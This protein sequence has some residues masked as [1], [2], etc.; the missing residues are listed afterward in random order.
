MGFRKQVE[1]L[2]FARGRDTFSGERGKKKEMDLGIS[3]HH[4][5]HRQYLLRAYY[6]ASNAVSDFHLLTHLILITI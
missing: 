1:A 3:N 4:H 2:A 5:H 6:V